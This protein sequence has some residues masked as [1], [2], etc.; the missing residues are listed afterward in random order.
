MD[1]VSEALRSLHEQQHGPSSPC[2]RIKIEDASSWPS[3][4]AFLVAVSLLDPFTP[5]RLQ[6]STATDASFVELVPRQSVTLCT[7]RANLTDQ[8]FLSPLWAA[9]W[10]QLSL[11]SSPSSSSSM[12]LSP[13]PPPCLHILAPL[14][15][16]AAS[17][18]STLGSLPY[19]AALPQTL[20]P[21]APPSSLRHLSLFCAA[22]RKNILAL[23]AAPQQI[24]AHHLDTGAAATLVPIAADPQGSSATATAKVVDW[25][26]LQ[27]NLHRRAKAELQMQT[28]AHCSALLSGLGALL[29][30]SL[31]AC[32][33]VG[34]ERGARAKDRAE[35]EAEGRRGEV[36]E[37]EEPAGPEAK[38][39]KPNTDTDVDTDTDTDTDSTST[40][41]APPAAMPPVSQL[42]F[43]LL[44]CWTGRVPSA[45]L[46]G[47]ARA[48]ASRLGQA[49]L[50]DVASLGEG[51]AAA[52]EDGFASVLW[53]CWQEE[54]DRGG[55]T[56]RVAGE[57]GDAGEAGEAGPFLC[58]LSLLL[59]ALSLVLAA[60][61]L[62]QLSPPLAAR[63]QRILIDGFLH[64][65][66]GALESAHGPPSSSS[67]SSSSPPS[68][69]V[70]KKVVS[71]L[72]ALVEVL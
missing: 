28:V 37:E 12:I 23:S 25:C 6:C 26:Q 47:A 42:L 4:C 17:H 70:P 72:T 61:C 15:A 9:A 35:C 27:A 34:G 7:S 31:L 50:R 41:T 68:V 20:Q 30:L 39:C 8:A 33:E 29:A 24:I 71:E 13:P 2:L 14:L 59:L 46:M 45:G 66:R 3:V 57:A 40:A 65:C 60:P 44:F 22:A 5:P 51:S 69:V 36:L 49:V 64:A 55:A 1:Y 67:S 56:T 11:A 16:S 62:P 58:P 21:R 18:C 54:A 63:L 32:R 10:Q 43:V 19:A 38:R 53:R 52:G 48:A